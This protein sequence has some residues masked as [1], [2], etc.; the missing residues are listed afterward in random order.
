MM[1]RHDGRSR[2][3][4]AAIEFALVLPVLVGLLMGAIEWGWYLRHEI[5][6]V[7][8]ARDAAAAGA[9]SKPA[10]G[11]D[12][13]ALARAWDALVEGHIDPARAHL[14]ADVVSSVYGPVISVDV[15]VDYDPLLRWVPTPS[16]LAAH[17]RT[18]LE[19]R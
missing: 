5:L 7:H 6:V 9:L 8:I 14:D 17:H 3:G 10:D 15:V 4:A 12:T 1:G 16:R 2:R 13:V 19:D 18:L 11:P